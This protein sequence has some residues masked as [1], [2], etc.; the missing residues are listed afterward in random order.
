[1]EPQ[2]T[3]M[4]ADAIARTD[5]D[6][7]GAGYR[8]GAASK[9]GRDP[10]TFAIIGAAMEVHRELGPGFLEGV[11]QDAMQIE[12]ST[13]NVAFEREPQVPVSYKGA[14]LGTAYRADFICYRNV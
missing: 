1:M 11:Y 5:A 13:R 14:I 10:E 7:L 4:S 12:L 3:Q 2:I 9:I 8:V 6:V